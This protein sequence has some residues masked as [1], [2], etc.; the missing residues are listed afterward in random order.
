FHS[1]PF[2]ARSCGASSFAG[3]AEPA[4]CSPLPARLRGVSAALALRAQPDRDRAE[5][6]LAAAPRRP[7]R[8]RGPLRA[9]PPRVPR[10][11]GCRADGARRPRLLLLRDV[12]LGC[13]PA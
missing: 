9:P 8:D 7:R 3:G 12:R 5:R 4:R 6:A 1:T 13:W 11:E 10:G 2:I